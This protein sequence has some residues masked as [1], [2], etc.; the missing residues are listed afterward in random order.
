MTIRSTIFISLQVHSKINI[1][2]PKLKKKSFLETSISLTKATKSE[3][4]DAPRG[5]TAPS[6]HSSPEGS[7]EDGFPRLGPPDHWRSEAFLLQG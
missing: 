2:I 7:Q 5:H 1:I 3:R 4:R 6:E